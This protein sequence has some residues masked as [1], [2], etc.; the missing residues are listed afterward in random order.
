M[1]VAGLVRVVRAALAVAA[2]RLGLAVL[3]ARGRPSTAAS[4]SASAQRALVDGRGRRD[5]A[6]PEAR[7]LDDLDLDVVAV[8]LPSS[9]GSARRSRAAST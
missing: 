7:D 3:A 6:A 9:R 5:V 1:L 8:A 4:A 2:Q